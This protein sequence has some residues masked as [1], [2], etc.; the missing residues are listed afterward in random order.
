MLS[1]IY[2]I[3]DNLIIYCNMI[4]FTSQFEYFSKLYQYNFFV[5]KSSC[6]SI[7]TY[8][9]SICHFQTL[10]LQKFVTLHN[11]MHCVSRNLKELLSHQISWNNTSAKTHFWNWNLINRNWLV[12]GA[13]NMHFCILCKWEN[14][15]DLDL[16]NIRRW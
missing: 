3:T 13:R 11:Q 2:V 15:C 10:E 14:I 12:Y 8:Q 7:N 9:K 16:R 4:H 6:Q 1:Y 5:R